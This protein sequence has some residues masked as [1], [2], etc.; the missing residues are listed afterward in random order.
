MTTSVYPTPYEMLRKW[1][2]KTPEK[3]YLRQPIDRVAHEKT[4]A[5]VH[6]E[7]LR[8]SAALRSLGLQK[9]DVV[10]ILGK[11]TAE[12]FISDFAIVAAGMIPAP[13]YF[14]AGTDTIRFILGHSGAK[15]IILGKLDDVE[16]AREAI[17]AGMITI[18]Q[19][20]D[21]LPCDHH[22]TDLIAANAP[23]ADVNQPSMDDIFSLIYTSG[24]TGNPKAIVTTFRN[25]GYGAQ[26]TAE[27]LNY[28]ENDRLLSYLPLA[29]IT[30]RAVVQYA[31]L[32][33]G[34]TV[35]FTESLATFPE[36][37]RNASPTVF[38]SVPRLWMKFQSG[39]LAKMP[40]KKLDWMLRVPILSGIV[41]KKIK[42]QLGLQNARIAASGAAPISPAV[43]HWFHKLGINISEGWGMSETTGMSAVNYPFRKEKIG[44]IG[45][46]PKGTTLKISQEGEVLI[47][48][49]GIVSQYHKDAETSAKT[50]RDGWLHTGDRGQIDAEG[51]LRITGR[52]K[53][54]FKTGKGKYVAPVPIESLLAE[55][56]YV[57]QICVTGLGLPQPVAIVVMADQGG[58]N[59]LQESSEEV[60]GLA[61]TLKKTNSRL[62][63]HERLSHIIVA[64]DP[65]TIENGLL[66]PTLKLKRNLIEKKYAD[67]I[68]KPSRNPVVIEPSL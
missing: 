16:A 20:Y 19:P 28:S 31:G 36:D 37:V 48:G 55:N 39:V 9:G 50:F 56:P 43:L 13:I 57:E 25:I 33:H 14:T 64:R 22:M 51:C 47:R 49:D 66:T 18:S 54:L 29:H 6:D 7:V 62:E 35:S 40:Q 52:V 42:A 30:E 65:W 38:I 4:W 2:A 67:L 61:E 24:T 26:S 32:Y 21:T 68:S 41:K 63:A 8:F 44:T 11:N 59:H 34:C 58:H 15:A 1:A 5:Q 17:P 23:L 53:E 3:V 45:A 27:H 46:P 60:A 10:A 12:W